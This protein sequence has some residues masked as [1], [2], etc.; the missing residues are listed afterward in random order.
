[1]QQLQDLFENEGGR[2]AGLDLRG[3]VLAL[4]QRL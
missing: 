3:L 4:Q 2:G 1:M